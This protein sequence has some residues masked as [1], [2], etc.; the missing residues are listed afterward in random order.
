MKKKEE[1]E[2]KLFKVLSNKEREFRAIILLKNKDIKI[3][4]LNLLLPNTLKRV[5]LLKG[6]INQ[7]F[8]LKQRRVSLMSTTATLTRNRRYHINLSKIRG[9]DSNMRLNRLLQLSILS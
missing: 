3:L 9:E 5:L 2:I 8:F 7:L 4:N 1:K 6:L